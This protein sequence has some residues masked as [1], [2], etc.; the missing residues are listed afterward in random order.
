MTQKPVFL[1]PAGLAKLQA[2]LAHLCDVRRQEVVE[3]I[4]QATQASGAVDEA[5]YED[6][7]NKQAFVE[8]RIRTLESL[9]QNAQIISGAEGLDEVV[10]IGSTVQVR[11][12]TGEEEEYTIVGSAEAQ[13]RDGRI[14]NESPV[15]RALLG[16]RVGDEVQ[17]LVPAGLVRLR[18]LSVH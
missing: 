16:R 4:H 15:G 14:S 2:E 10:R 5:E 8:G 9:I 12:A 1:T 3:R 11:E 7:K 6:A 17:V 13:P 18:I